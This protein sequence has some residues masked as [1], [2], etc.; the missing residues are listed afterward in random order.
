MKENP[1]SE[2]RNPKQ[3]PTGKLEARNPK[4]ESRN[5]KQYQ[6]TEVL[7]Q[8][9]QELTNIFGAIFRKSE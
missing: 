5:P 8:E 7:V 9:A 3:T 1:K 4:S 2:C 6:M